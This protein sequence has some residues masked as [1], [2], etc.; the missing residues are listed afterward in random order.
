MAYLDLHAE[1]P[2]V[3]IGRTLTPSIERRSLDRTE[4]EAVMLARTDR[5]SSIRPV[6]TMRRL[7]QRLFGLRAPNP[8]ADPRLEALR[9][10]AVAVARD[11]LASSDRQAAQ[12]AS[13]GFTTAQIGRARS[14]AERFRP[15]ERA[16]AGHLLLLP[17]GIT[18]GTVL[19]AHTLG[20]AVISAITV[21]TIVLPVWAAMAPRR[22]HGG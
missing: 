13:H 4:R 14:I 15:A 22:A 7:A 10:F 19:V 17:T 9:R 20:D 21:M 12:L 5:R 1:L 18:V 2:M 11:R 16:Q 3:T 6:G 8:L